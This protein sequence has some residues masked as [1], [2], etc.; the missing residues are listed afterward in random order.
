MAKSDT[1]RTGQI[2]PRA[3]GLRV[4]GNGSSVFVNPT[5]YILAQVMLETPQEITA[6]IED[7]AYRKGQSP[8][9]VRANLEI[10]S[11][12]IFCLIS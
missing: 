1:R 3:Y 12:I 11:S 7:W 9:Q 2:L 10:V 6:R 5:A 4:F 8:Q